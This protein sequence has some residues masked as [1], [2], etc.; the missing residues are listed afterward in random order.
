MSL[1]VYTVVIFC[2]VMAIIWML[3]EMYKTAKWITVER[4]KMEV[5]TRILNY[6]HWQQKRLFDSLIEKLDKKEENL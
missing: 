1:W 2:L 6:I 5:R 4:E 3:R